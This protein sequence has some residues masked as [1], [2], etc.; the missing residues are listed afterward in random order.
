MTTSSKAPANLSFGPSTRCFRSFVA[1]P[2][3]TLILF[4]ALQST[5][6][7][8]LELAKDRPSCLSLGASSVFAESKYTHSKQGS[9]AINWW[10]RTSLSCLCPPASLFRD[11]ILSESDQPTLMLNQRC[12]LLV[13]QQLSWKTEKSLRWSCDW[14]AYQ[15]SVT[16]V[17]TVQFLLL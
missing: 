6:Q 11:W 15:T 12:N 3:R 7:Q 1:S 16:L 4:S 5:L 10:I 9:L 14:V 8:V 13:A 17:P 2:W